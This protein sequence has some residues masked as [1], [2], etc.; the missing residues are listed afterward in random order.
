MKLFKVIAE[1][2]HQVRGTQVRIGFVVTASTGNNAVDRVR[3]GYD[4]GGLQGL[5]VV[6]KEETGDVLQVVRV[7]ELI[8]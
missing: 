8:F 7:D 5:T 4:L 6:A 3:D 1:G 2:L